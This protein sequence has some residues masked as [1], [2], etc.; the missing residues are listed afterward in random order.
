M[1]HNNLLVMA[2]SL[3]LLA[4]CGGGGDASSKAT[5]LSSGAQEQSSSSSSSS[6]TRS[7]SSKTSV[8]VPTEAPF[9]TTLPAISGTNVTSISGIRSGGENDAVANPGF[10]YEWHGDGASS[11]RGLAVR[12]ND[13]DK[14]LYPTIYPG[15]GI[16]AATFNPD[17]SHDYGLAWGED[18]L[19]AGYSGLYGPG[20]N[21]HRGAFAGRYFEYFSEDPVLS[22]KLCSRLC[23]GMKERG[24]YAYLKHFALNDQETYR[25][26]VCTWANEQ[27]IREIYLKPYQIV[28]EDRSAECVMTGFNR[29]GVLWTGNHGFLNTV[30][31]GEWGSRGIAVSDWWTG[32]YMNHVGGIYNGNDIPDGTSVISSWNN[33]KQGHPAF[34]WAMR[35]SAHRILYTVAHSNAMNG[36]SSNTEV[37][38]LTPPW[39]GKLN[40]AKTAVDTV[41]Y[42][43]AG[44]FLVSV[45]LYF[46]IGRKK[47]I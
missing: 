45:V 6:R 42:V 11:N 23:A 8:S 27:S 17:L 14:N 16:V 18:C 30:F 10:L 36:L 40:T 47:E 24:V 3:L 21:A 35:E 7:S 1:K 46:T 43:A 9:P 12:L 34:A 28:V 39:I 13:P 37:I 4:S 22:G 29:L 25:E 5:G 41:F 38:T 20:L 44:F 31:H 32:S 15:S 33:Y 26:G 2:T 19:W